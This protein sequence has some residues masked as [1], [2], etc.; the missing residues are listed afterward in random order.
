MN[1]YLISYIDEDDEERGTGIVSTL[2]VQALNVDAA[3]ELGER[4]IVGDI[5][6][7]QQIK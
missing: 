5:I 7:V 4:E 2:E 1:K 6:K 3:I